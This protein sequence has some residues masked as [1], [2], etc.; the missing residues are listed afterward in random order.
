MR[1]YRVDEDWTEYTGDLS[2]AANKWGLPGVEPCVACGMGGGWAGIEYPCVDLSALPA[3]ELKKLLDP[4]PVPF[5]EFARLRELVRP[6]APKGAALEPGARLGPL[7]GTASGSFGQL[8]LLGWT[9]VARHE[10][11]ER[12]REAGVRGLQGCP[13]QV[14]FRGK[15][16]PELREL[17][18]ELHGHLHVD[19]QPPGRR[20]PCSTCGSEAS[21]SLP[22]RYWLAAE[23]LP[24]HVDL[25]RLRDFPTLIIATERM[26]EAA[27]RLELDGVTFQPL[28]TR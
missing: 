23:S 6:L 28:E 20:P 21:Y 24:G 25:F 13:L 14:R 1:F 3:R 16:P 9:L 10:A 15:N 8:Y 26:V 11:L 22:E 2:N 18:L 19:C 7:V 5:D 17:Q 4:W 27:R 12:L